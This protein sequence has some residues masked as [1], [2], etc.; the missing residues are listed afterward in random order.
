MGTSY[1][2]SCK[3]CDY[4]KR[5][6]IGIGMMYDLNNLMNVDAD[7]PFLKLLIRSKKRIS[8][9][10]ELINKKNAIIANNYEHK[11]YR[12]PTC[13]EFYERFFIHIDYDEGS[14]EVDY[15]CTKCKTLLEF[16]NNDVQEELKGINLNKYPC[17]KC[18]KYSLY[19]SEGLNILWD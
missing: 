11:I 1:E 10:K 13:G 4:S 3:E 12:C 9:I 14:Y 19:E 7:Y 18:G 6:I 16:L 2:I 15:R 17:P 5:F 8:F